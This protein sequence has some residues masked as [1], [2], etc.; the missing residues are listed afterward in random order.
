METR[1]LADYLNELLKIREIKDKSLNGLVV[2]NTEKVSKVALAVDASLDTFMKAKQAGA[3]F[4]FVHHGLWWGESLPLSGG[5]YR[6]IKFLIEENIALYVTHL[7]LDIHPE[8]GNN[9]QA[10]KLL[11]WPVKKDF[12]NYNDLLI[13]KEVLFESPRK[14]EDLVK[15]L[16]DKLKVN[17]VVWDFGLKEIKRLGYVS[18]DALDLLPQAIELR[19]DAYVTGEPKHS[20]YWMAKEEKIN[21]IFTGHYLGETLGV[22]A[23][24]KH[25]KNKF[26]L[27]VEF[28]YL[29]TG[30]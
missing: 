9:A 23:I 16:K 24:G 26:N 1:K 15:D 10:A 27:K 29:P 3:D 20:Y 21:V 13:G 28:L 6:R 22:K 14:L 2:D 17:P 12:G 19:L 5:L 18:G 30:Y 11:A 25:L 7:P 8:F 4:L